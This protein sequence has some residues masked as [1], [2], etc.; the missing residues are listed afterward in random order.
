MNLDVVASVDAD[1]RKRLASVLMEHIPKPA[2]ERGKLVIAARGGRRKAKIIIKAVEGK[3][4][5]DQWA[6]LV[7]NDASAS[8]ACGLI[9]ESTQAGTSRRASDVEGGA[10]DFRARAL[11]DPSM[12]TGEEAA[13]RFHVTRQYIHE[14]YRK[15]QLIGL[16]QPGRERGIR[17]PSW[18]FDDGVAGEPLRRVL[19]ELKGDAWSRW[20]FFVSPAPILADLSP[21]TLLKG[22]GEPAAALRRSARGL[23]ALGREERLKRVLEAAR[24]YESDS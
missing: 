23:L 6:F 22:E 15:G 9:Q 13:D 18:Q 1:D 8:L 2:T 4:A 19:A 12:L 20:L 3:G 10:G 14:L 24:E 5:P 21:V 16:I 11:A 17:Y 7:T